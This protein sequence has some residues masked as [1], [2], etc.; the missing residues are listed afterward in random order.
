MTDAASHECRSAYGEYKVHAASS[1]QK[2]ARFSV[3]VDRDT[4]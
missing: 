3:I 2:K 1:L 4:K